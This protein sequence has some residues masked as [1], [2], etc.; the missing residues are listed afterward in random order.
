MKETEKGT[1]KNYE[2]E[3]GVIPNR[4]IR[5]CLYYNSNQEW[6]QEANQTNN[7]PNNYKIKNHCIKGLIRVEVHQS[8]QHTP[9]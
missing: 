5:N 2:K 4:K 8:L 9:K 1:E 3:G 7:Y 6:F